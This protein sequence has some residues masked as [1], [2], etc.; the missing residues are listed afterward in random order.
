MKPSVL[1]SLALAILTTGVFAEDAKVAFRTLCLGFSGDL[2]S[3]AIPG[4]EPGK[5]QEV[6][7]YTGLSE[8]IEGRFADGEARFYVPAAGEGEAPRLVAK[9]K[10]GTSARQLFLFVPSGKEGKPAYSLK[11]YNDDLKSFGM[12]HVRA[13][14]AS[15]VPVRFV[16]SGQTTP[17]IPPGKHAVFPHS[18]KVNEYNMYPVVVEFLGK[19]DQ[20]VKGQSVSW[21]ST[22]RRREVVV[23]MIDP[24]FN[25]PVV[26]MYGDV[27]P[28]VEEQQP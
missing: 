14:N 13:I 19:G 21:K 6:P 1:F 3:V 27:P 17:A 2:N 24:K 10:L 22:D 20:W 18:Q 12:G 15:A 5:F 26:K 4:K 25:Q 7:L 9:A 11:C 23:T 16:I 28:W 8:V